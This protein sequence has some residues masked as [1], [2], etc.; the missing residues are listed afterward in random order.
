MDIRTLAQPTIT[1]PPV[2]VPGQPQLTFTV[3]LEFEWWQPQP[4]DDVHNNF[5]NMQ[6]QVSNGKT[7]ALNVWTFTYLTT[8]RQN[9]EQSGESLAGRYLVPPDLLVEK[10]DRPLLETI[11]I[12]LIQ[13][14]SL[15]E[16]WFVPNHD[17]ASSDE[18][19]E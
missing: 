1:Y 11:V 7:Y 2:T 15:R 17:H 18:K 12:D 13:S 5:F 4:D 10:L 6:I 14:N 16:E 19:S 8:A 9:D 3:W